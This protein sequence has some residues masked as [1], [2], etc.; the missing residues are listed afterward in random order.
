MANEK[1]KGYQLITK[2][3][4]YNTPQKLNKYRILLVE[5]NNN[6]KLIAVRSFCLGDLGKE[7]GCEESNQQKVVV[8]SM[9]KDYSLI[10]TSLAAVMSSFSTTI[11]CKNCKSKTK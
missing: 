1:N 4:K 10:L 7:G 3:T 5:A 9:W 6:N 2:P 8:G 11:G